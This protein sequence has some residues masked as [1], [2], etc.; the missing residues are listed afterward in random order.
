MGVMRELGYMLH[1]QPSVGRY[2][3]RVERSVINR[4][5]RQFG[6]HQGMAVESMTYARVRDDESH[7]WL[8]MLDYA[9]TIHDRDAL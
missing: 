2:W 8:P 5:W 4:V 3:E 9:T 1:S 6:R 7:G